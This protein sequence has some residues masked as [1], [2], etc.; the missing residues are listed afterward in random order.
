MKTRTIKILD[1]ISFNTNRIYLTVCEQ[2]DTDLDNKLSTERDVIFQNIYL[3][4]SKEL[5][6]N[7]LDEKLQRG[8]V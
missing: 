6:S 5:R 8:F 7:L 1:K 2:L 4:I 3:Q